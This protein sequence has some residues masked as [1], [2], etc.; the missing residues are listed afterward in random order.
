MRPAF[1]SWRVGEHSANGS[2]SVRRHREGLHN[3][4]QPTTIERSDQRLSS[5]WRT[6]DCR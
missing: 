5:S 2:P 1:H 4:G 6:I 3:L